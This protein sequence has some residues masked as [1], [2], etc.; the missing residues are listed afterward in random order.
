MLKRMMCVVLCLVLLVG[1]FATGVPAYAAEPSSVRVLYIPLDDR[2]MNDQQARLMAEGME[3]TL[4]MPERDLYATKLDGGEK[5]SNGTQYGDRGALFEYLQ[6]NADEADLFILSLDQLL[7]GGLMN[8]R[9][10]E[11]LSPIVLSDGTEVSEYDVIDYIA[12][13][14]QEKPVYI[15]DSIQR[16][17]T[18][19]EFGGY[20][21]VDYT[22][23]RRY[24]RVGRPMLTG[25][26]LTLEN[27]IENYN[28]SQNGTEAY[29]QA[30]FS[31]KEL[32]YFLGTADFVETPD[33]SEDLE[34]HSMTN[35]D[36]DG[37][38]FAGAQEVMASQV[39]DSGQG[40]GTDE[41]DDPGEAQKSNSLL[42]KYLRIRQRKITLLDY[43]LRT[44][45][46]MERV[47][48]IL[49]VDDSTEG[50]SIH[51]NEI[52]YAQSLMHENDQIFSA[53]DGLAQTALAQAYQNYCGNPQIRFSVTYYGNDKEDVGTFNYQT[54]AQMIEKLISYHN[55]VLVTEEP[56]VSL[57]VYTTSDDEN[58]RN[59]D[60]LDLISQINQNEADH[61]PTILMD[62]AGAESTT[63]KELYLDGIHMGMLLSYSG[64]G[65]GVVRVH[66]AISQGVGRY[67]YLRE[68]DSPTED[69]QES[70]VKSLLWSFVNEYYS[71]TGGRADMQNYLAA[72]GYGSSFGDISP[73]KVSDIHARLTAVVKDYGEGVT[74]NF[75]TSNFI[76]SLK[77]YRL[78]SI[79]SAGISSCWFPW[80]RQFEID[81]EVTC[82]LSENPRET[83]LHPQYCNGITK[84]RF[85]PNEPLTREQAAK[86]LNV[87]SSTELLDES[88]CRFQ[89]VTP[90]ARPYVAA[91]E[92]AGYIKGY[93][94]GTFQ[95]N[96]Q[97][98]RKEFAQMLFQYMKEKGIVLEK[99]SNVTFKDVD[100]NGKEWFVEAV[101]VLGDAEIIQGYLDGRFMPDNLIT[102]AEAVAMLGRLFERQEELGSGLMKV[103]RY[104]DVP[105]AFWG[106][107]AIQDASLTHFLN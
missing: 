79:S 77:P 54:N 2:T 44:L 45:S 18:S 62:F 31:V 20:D 7:S 88:E 47:Y 17:A 51:V 22:L 16:L 37:D 105:A 57:L 50:N 43:A 48:Y 28:L 26:D 11:E 101:Y 68:A 97:I 14:A 87:I 78:G 30:G 93:P 96:K 82:E 64:D 69:A 49:G 98:T 90:W 15:I 36:Y 73:I 80:L 6:A 55:G 75:A 33:I 56:D 85:Y 32:A 41:G 27:I 86:M 61:V 71:S 66:M 13:L 8:S 12:Q 100:R 53:L 70:F 99:Q 103:C 24:G 94:D 106:Y 21:L 104:T 63:L 46:G 89:D 60:M 5:N 19:N 29:L 52:A 72:R 42:A 76:A 83:V 74:D 91:A 84:D 35:Q 40:E 107:G 38:V 1:C 65:D 102:R 95:G 4:M 9:C 34:V 81:G 25:S 59:R 58:E 67:L 39:A 3:M 92:K 23:S 10:L